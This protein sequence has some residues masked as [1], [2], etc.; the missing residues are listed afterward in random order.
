MLEC[1][2]EKYLSFLHSSSIAP[3]FT[4][5]VLCH[6]LES[7]LPTSGSATSL[8]RCND[9]GHRRSCSP[10]VKSNE[11]PK[12]TSSSGVPPNR[13]LIPRTAAAPGSSRL[14]CPLGWTRYLWTSRCCP[15][16]PMSLLQ[17]SRSNRGCLDPNRPLQPDPGAVRPGRSS[18][19]PSSPEVPRCH[20]GGLLSLSI[21]DLEK[22]QRVGS[23]EP[24]PKK[25]REPRGRHPLGL[26]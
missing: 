9:G 22:C 8:L 24:K 3:T 7:S 12:L 17:E 26:T 21:A 18:W 4:A 23:R 13:S 10:A 20:G 5:A 19:P 14:P 6:K 11:E 16:I 2:G 25:P 1:P 15:R